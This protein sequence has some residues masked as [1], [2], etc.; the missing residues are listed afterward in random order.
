MDGRDFCHTMNKLEFKK[1]HFLTLR[2]V[3]TLKD[4]SCVF[5]LFLPINPKLPTLLLTVIHNTYHICFWILG[6]VF[7]KIMGKIN[8]FFY[9]QEKSKSLAPD[10]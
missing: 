10:R 5:F 4:H 8:F 6:S 2:S 3:L 9:Q 7:S 1:D